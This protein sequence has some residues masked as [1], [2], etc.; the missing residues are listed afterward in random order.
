MPKRDQQSE[1]EPDLTLEVERRLDPLYSEPPDGFVASRNELAK[2]LRAEGERGAAERVKKLRRPSRA[3]WLI[4]R[5]S[6]EDPER[7]RRFTA[8]VDELAEAQRRVL[9]E[10]A[11]PAELRDAAA[12]ERHEVEGMVEA[13][14]RVGGVGGRRASGAIIDRVAETLHAAGA[15]AELRSRVLHGRVE[16]EATAATI[17]ISALSG[18]GKP[19][20]GRAPKRSQRREVERAG[21]ELA[22]LRERLEVAEARRDQ[23]VS[24]VDA[25]EGDL[26]R[27][28]ADLATAK[29]EVKALQR[30]V[31][32]AER[33]LPADDR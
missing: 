25:A 13:A 29:R 17:G 12:G 10:D 4:N 22:R 18:A 2:E 33:Q 3:A 7:A 20:R 21:R 23:S 15:D 30:E 5:V 6:A 31:S 32:A 11:D 27:A 8:A 1:A 14:R 28:R 24:R 16:R 19:R 9:D 26:R